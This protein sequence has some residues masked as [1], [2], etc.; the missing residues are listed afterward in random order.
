VKL[1]KSFIIFLTFFIILISIF[2]I[3]FLW[4]FIR[5]TY[6]E[7]NLFRAEAFYKKIN[8]N[9]NTLRFLIFVITPI[10]IFLLSYIFFFKT[11]DINPFKKD[12][13]LCKF[14]RKN[15]K[16][17]KEIDIFSLVF[18]LFVFIEFSF[19]NH[20]NFLTKIDI[21]HEGTNL[22]PP[23]NF[24]NYD[25]F[26]KSTYYDYGLF[27]N[28]RPLLIWNILGI[29]T[30]GSAR[31]LDAILIL[32]NKI[33][34]IL[35]SRK[36][37]LF[38]NISSV[39]KIFFFL[40][41]TLVIINLSKYFV[42][43]E[44]SSRS[45][46][47]LIF[48]IFFFENIKKKNN[49]IITFIVGFFSSMSFLWWIDIAF[50]INAIII[51]YFFLLLFLKEFKKILFVI[52]GVFI[53]WIF[54]L[55]F[56]GTT[57]TLEFIWQIKFTFKVV[58]YLNFI[59]FPKPFGEH[60]DSYRGT[61]SLLLIIINGI[62]CSYLCL[63]KKK[64]TNFEIK[65]ILLILFFSSVVF[66][67]SAL[68]RS[69]SYHIRYGSGI[70]F[71]LFFFIITYLAVTNNFIKKNIFLFVS[72]L[73]KK[74]LFNLISISFIFFFTLGDQIKT[75]KNGDGLLLNLKKTIYLEDNI[76]L[77]TDDKLF[78]D[79]FKKISKEDKCV[80]IL[81]DYLALPYFLKK[82][83][84]T[85]FFTPAFIMQNFTENRFLEQLKKN[86]PNFILYDYEIKQQTEKLNM[87][88]VDEYIKKNYSKH[89]IIQN[90]WEV[91]KKN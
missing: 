41:F 18:I 77:N 46:L 82:P 21:F 90:K 45:L 59:E 35:I 56:F 60:K 26:W 14:E 68:V 9:T 84:C 52:C 66:F 73:K 75:I 27:G 51:F 72:I 48:L 39:L 69:D 83:S 29:E 43:P 31:V 4:D 15:F 8:P 64:I 25:S 1:R 3:T 6:N 80:Q 24:K 44:I 2:I 81:T 13:F 7:N 76:F 30:I 5:L 16:E 58:E 33:F 91:Y 22:V 28:N 11:L 79:E 63:N 49:F 19:L 54:F 87:P 32:L 62:F 71:L 20:N 85:Q 42:V 34:L 67:K 89:S 70:T 40:F 23:I 50:Y 57:E 36:I 38:L 17:L 65:I 74:K 61:K 55:F 37:S 47:F 88:N 86:T 78:I 12:F 10:S 53:S